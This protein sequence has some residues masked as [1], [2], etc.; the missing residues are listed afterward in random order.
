MSYLADQ[1]GL[2]ILGDP[3]LRTFYSTFNYKTDQ[4][5]LAVSSNAPPGTH[6]SRYY[7]SAVIALFIAFS[8]AATIVVFVIIYKCYKKQQYV[9]PQ[10]NRNGLDSRLVRDYEAH[11]RFANQL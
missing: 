2:Y 7:S 10:P 6:I 1:Q 3:F 5:C 11:P 8:V 9:S 4:V